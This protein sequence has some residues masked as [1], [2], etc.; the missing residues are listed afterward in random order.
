MSWQRLLRENVG[1]PSVLRKL[2]SMRDKVLMVCGEESH[3]LLARKKARLILKEVSRAP[4]TR[5]S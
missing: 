2:H 1:D 3:P 4:R 5:R